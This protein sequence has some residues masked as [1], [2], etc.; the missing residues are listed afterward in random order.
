MNKV[1]GF[2]YLYITGKIWNELSKLS[3]LNLQNLI[4]SIT[5]SY[6]VIAYKSEGGDLSSELYASKSGD[7]AVTIAE[8]AVLDN[9]DGEI[10]LA[11]VPQ[12]VVDFSSAVPN[13]IYTIYIQ[14]KKTSIEVG[15][16]GFVN[17][18][19]QVT[20]TGG[21]FSKVC[22]FQYILVEGSS[23]GNDGIYQVS[24]TINTNT[25]E[26]TEEFTGTTESGLSWKILGYTGKP[27]DESKVIY[28]YEGYDIT[29]S[30]NRD[31]EGYKIARVTISS[32]GSVSIVEDL[33]S[34][35]LY[36][37]KPIAEISADIIKKGKLN[38]ITNLEEKWKAGEL[39]SYMN[40]I[41]DRGIITGLAGTM[42]S[43][44]SIKI[45]A[46]AAIDDIGNRIYLP[47]DIQ[48][49]ISNLTLQPGNNYLHL[50]Y[51]SPGSYEFVWDTSI[52]S[53]PNFVLIGNLLDKVDAEPRYEFV[54][55]NQK[56]KATFPS[57]V[58]TGPGDDYT[59]GQLYYRSS[60]QKYHMR[61]P[62]SE[63]SGTEELIMVDEELLLE[64]LNAK[65]A[66]VAK[67][68]RLR[69]VLYPDASK[70]GWFISEGWAMPRIIKYQFIITN[71]FITTLDT[72]A[73]SS[74]SHLLADYLSR[75][76]SKVVKASGS[77]VG[78][79]VSNAD[80]DGTNAY[81]NTGVGLYFKGTSSPR[82]IQLRVGSAVK[83]SV[84]MEEVGGI[85]NGGGGTP[86]NKLY[87]GEVTIKATDIIIAP[88]VNQNQTQD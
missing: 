45:I 57:I 38:N 11:L 1:I 14:P 13:A 47:S 15:T 51:K 25:L 35:N 74:G 71:W 8:G 88:P 16:V 39:S 52:L 32:G 66:D 61:R 60:N 77:T 42:P 55:A 83:G 76:F 58:T 65:L 84:D 17:G 4:K 31:L 63:G 26:L 73:Y 18:S 82:K 80:P 2:P 23:S 54:S 37:Q 64:T 59:P 85:A 3:N 36:T 53:K 19:K 40:D 22:P 6:G 56:T 81:S 87:Y 7:N 49:N 62:A 24:P 69:F 67:T 5:L 34:S 43:D 20:I 70:D 79:I 50:T 46:G 29:R 44:T 9:K 78:N 41:F 12:T 48:W 27:I 10:I 21:N 86:I 30:T 72:E 28:E 75:D 68:E 33:R